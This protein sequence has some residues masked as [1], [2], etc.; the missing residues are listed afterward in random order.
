MEVENGIRVLLV[1]PGKYAEE[2]RLGSDLKS[3]QDFVGGSIE[4]FYPFEEADCIVC[5]DEGKVNGMSPNRAV[6]DDQGDIA[7]IVCGSFFVADCSDSNFGSLSDDQMEKYKKLFL[8]PER[9][10]RIGTQIVARKYDPALS[11]KDVSR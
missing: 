4:G 1:H 9:F 3:M 10:Y 8:K 6:Y 2:G 11:H 5:N 7:D